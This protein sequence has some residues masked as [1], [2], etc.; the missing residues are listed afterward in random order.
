[1]LNQENINKQYFVQVSKEQEINQLEKNN[2]IINENEN[3]SKVFLEE[4]KRIQALIKKES[5]NKKICK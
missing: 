3:N 1:M 5:S 2:I 4:I